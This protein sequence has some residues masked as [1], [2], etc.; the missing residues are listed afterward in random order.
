MKYKKVLLVDDDIDDRLIFE[1]ILQEID[2]TIG[3]ASAENGLEMIDYLDKSPE[4][5]LPGLIIL[6][7]NMPR[8]TGKESL[9]FL[10]QSNRYRHIPIIIYSTYQVKDFFQECLEMGA[11]DVVSKPDTI[12]SY[13]DMINQF[14]S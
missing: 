14:F 9:V 7:Q 10:K 4:E 3:M 11:V 5:D 6:D 1:Q 2:P 13:R 8:M 12:Q